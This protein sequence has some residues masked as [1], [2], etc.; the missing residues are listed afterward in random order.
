MK[1]STAATATVATLIMFL[2]PA[3]AEDSGWTDRIDFSGDFRLRY[4]G[5]DE[6]F[7][8]ER[9]AMRFRGRFG[10][11]ATA[12][13]NVKFVLRLATGGDNPVS[14]N[15]SFDGGFSTKDIGV[16]LA[17][18]DWQISD[19]LNF[20]GGKMKNPFF[21]AGSVQFIWDNDLTPEGLAVKYSSGLFFGAAG[22]FS[23][24]ERSDSDDSWLFVA[25][26]GIS[27]PFGESNKLTVGMGY[28]AYTNTIGNI[29]F[30]NGK[31]KGNTLDANDLYI[32]EYKNT[33]VF[34]QVDTKLAAWPVQIFAHFAKNNEVSR[35]DIAYTYGVNIGSS[36]DKGQAQ[37]TWIYEDVEADSVIGTFNDSDFG[38]GG[39]DAKGHLLKVKYGIA[40]KIF[41]GGTF[42]VNKVERFQGIEHDYNRFQLDLEI[43]FN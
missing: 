3:Y 8:V 30:Y 43:K 10:F 17:Y 40:K 42:F 16:D 33:E 5:I 27:I 36:R 15:Q 23:V 4:E 34:A 32:F 21:K 25:Q 13:D 41:V 6:E 39:T 20:Y 9:N 2:A 1:S 24:E 19:T 38:G 28:L 31:A 18:V 7:E 22:G 37:F 35:E 29:A 12:S 14:T 26:G 11:T